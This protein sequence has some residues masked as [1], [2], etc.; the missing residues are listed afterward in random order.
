M[1]SLARQKFKDGVFK[2]PP[3]QVV[4]H[5]YKNTS[6]GHVMRKLLVDLW[7]YLDHDRILEESEHSPTDFSVDLLTALLQQPAVT[8]SECLKQALFYALKGAGG[9]NGMQ[10]VTKTASHT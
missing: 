1:V 10:R 9:T 6:K 8:T 7:T 5:L 2:P 3:G 4:Q